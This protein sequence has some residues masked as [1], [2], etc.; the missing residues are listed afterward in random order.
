MLADSQRRLEQLVARLEAEEDSSVWKTRFQELEEAYE[1][2]RTRA[3]ELSHQ[4]D[5][6]RRRLQQHRPEVDN[7]VDARAAAFRKLKHSRKVIR[8]L[9]GERVCP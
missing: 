4:N 3:N 5:E 7:A 6:L 1:E 9:L 8:D 2:E